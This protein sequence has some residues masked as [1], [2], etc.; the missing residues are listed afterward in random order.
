M[1]RTSKSTPSCRLPAPR[2]TR[3]YRLRALEPLEDRTLPA[4][5]FLPDGGGRFV[6]QFSEDVPGAA[7]TLLLRVNNGGQVEY[8]FDG[9]AYS[10]DL[11]SAAAG[12]QPLAAAAVSR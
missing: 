9:A 4:V 8:S 2:K 11:N 1:R 12:G 7:D 5:T 3:P 10:T 6:V